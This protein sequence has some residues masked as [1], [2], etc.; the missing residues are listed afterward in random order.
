MSIYYGT[1]YLLK[2]LYTAPKPSLHRS[3]EDM[4][5]NIE[6][7][8]KYFLDQKKNI[9]KF[10]ESLKSSV[11]RSRMIQSEKTETNLS[12]E[13][14][15]QKLNGLNFTT[16]ENITT[17]L[18]I[19]N[20][21][22][23][24]EAKLYDKKYITEKVLG[25]LFETLTSRSVIMLVSIL[26][27]ARAIY[28][29][30]PN[31]QILDFIILLFSILGGI[32]ITMKIIFSKSIWKFIF[33][34]TVQYLLLSWYTE[35]KVIVE[36]P[37]PVYF[38][39]LFI[40][41]EKDATQYYRELSKIYHPDRQGGSNEEFVKM[42][43]EYEKIKKYYEP[44]DKDAWYKYFTVNR[45]SIVYDN[46]NSPFDFTLDVDRALFKDTFWVD[47][48]E[49]NKDLWGDSW[50]NKFRTDTCYS[51]PDLTDSGVS[52]EELHHTLNTNYIINTVKNIDK[53][54]RKSHRRRS[55]SKS[56]RRYRRRSQSKSRRKYRRRSQSK[57]RYRKRS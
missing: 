34:T 7:S 2:Y 50:A 36:K 30:F 28:L 39:D 5:K 54:Y 14:I 22:Q 3:V 12:I 24:I 15:E 9:V 51:I 47:L 40:C 25:K 32:V 44:K 8:K 55:Q 18:K 41:S 29:M 20:E 43:E 1:E 45:S 26:Y 19:S 31:I 49:I 46:P 11:Q 16:L 52:N 17:L 57:K 48:P 42:Q 33:L 6:N 21:L 23:E 37:D 56:R 13:N 27:C 10:A 38:K 35:T 4:V 53:E